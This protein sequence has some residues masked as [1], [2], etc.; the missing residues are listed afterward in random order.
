MNLNSRSRIHDL[1]LTILIPWFCRANFLSTRIGN[2]EMISQAR[3]N[4]LETNVTKLSNKIWNFGGEVGEWVY[5]T[6]QKVKHSGRV[7][8]NHLFAN[9]N[10]GTCDSLMPMSHGPCEMDWKDDAD[11]NTLHIL[12]LF[13]YKPEKI[14]LPTVSLLCQNIILLNKLIYN[15]HEF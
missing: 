7:Q 1:K 8:I 12:H 15:C 11:I 14:P 10:D 3:N 13:N 6:T 2:I 4:Y 5:I 9:L